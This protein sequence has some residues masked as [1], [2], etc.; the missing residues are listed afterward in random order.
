MTQISCL[1]VKRPELLGK[2]D[3]PSL[4]EIALQAVAQGR[5]DFGEDGGFELVAL[6]PVDLR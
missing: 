5:V 1:R 2:N 3:A 4:V 6:V